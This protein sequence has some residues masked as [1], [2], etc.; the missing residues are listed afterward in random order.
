MMVRALFLALLGAAVANA[1]LAAAQITPADADCGNCGI[2]QSIT[3]VSQRQQWTPLGSV[4]EAG[5][6]GGGPGGQPGSA[7]MFSIGPG[8]T[9]RGM[10]V[11]GA[12]GGAAY[13]QKPNEYQRQRWDVTVKMDSGPPPRVV[14]L[15]YEPFV[16]EGDRVRV[17]GNQLELVNP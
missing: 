13:A 12:A 3:P 7:T 11:V 17:F 14:N 5:A 1:L 8:F 6:M 10:V 2:V 9:N 15:S 16:Q 4:P